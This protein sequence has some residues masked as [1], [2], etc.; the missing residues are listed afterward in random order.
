MEL[1]VG[2]GGLDEFGPASR[3]L[4]DEDRYGHQSTEDVDAELNDVG[5]DDRLHS[6]QERVDHRDRCHDRDG[7]FGRPTCQVLEHGRGEKQTE[8]IAQGSGEKKEERSG[9]SS[10]SPKAVLEKLIDGEDL[11][12][13]V[14]GQ[15]RTWPP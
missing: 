3:Q 8:S 10:R 5:P 7:G 1:A 9:G 15:E 2:A 13:K 12:T 4:V 14:G 6:A 11:P